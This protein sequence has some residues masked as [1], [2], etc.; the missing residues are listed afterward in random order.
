MI[1]PD[2]RE[3]EGCPLPCEKNENHK[4][5]YKNIIKQK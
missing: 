1:V 5:K 3:E 4:T 2:G